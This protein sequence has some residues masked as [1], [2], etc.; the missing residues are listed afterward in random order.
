MNDKDDKTQ[1]NVTSHNQTGGITAYNVNVGK[2]QRQID[3]HWRSLLNKAIVEYPGREIK[4]MTEMG[5]KEAYQLG[6]Q[7]FSYLKSQGHQ[8]PGGVGRMMANVPLKTAVNI[9]PSKPLIEIFIGTQ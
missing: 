9:N 7:I 3:D 4:I 5:D 6:E 2:P 1:I 8:I